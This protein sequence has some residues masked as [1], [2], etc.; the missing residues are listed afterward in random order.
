MVR[1]FDRTVHPR[2]DLG[3]LHPHVV[4]DRVAHRSAERVDLVLVGPLTDV[5][6]DREVPHRDVAA[7][8]LLGPLPVQANGLPAFGRVPSTED[9]V[10]RTGTAHRHLVDDHVVVDGVGAGRDPHDAA[11]GASGVDGLLQA[12]G[13]VGGAG[14]IGTEVGDDVDHVRG[15]GDRRA[16][17]FEDVVEL[18]AGELGAERLR[19]HLALAGVNLD[20]RVLLLELRH[21]GQVVLAVHLLGLRRERV[22]GDG[23]DAVAGAV[24]GV[25]GVAGGGRAQE[26]AGGEQQ[27][28]GLTAPGSGRVSG[29]SMNDSA[30]RWW[31]AGRGSVGR[32]GGA[33]YAR[34][35]YFYARS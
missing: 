6:D 19:V 34:S 11:L 29:P 25:V 27:A 30:R 1:L 12:R 8:A 15:L 17:E 13:V 28:G 23:D 3:V 33:R 24:G 26:E 31:V 16:D 32:R 7:A 18:A 4:D 14:G 9:G 5:A 35:R 2:A 10:P 22:D 21:V 20:L